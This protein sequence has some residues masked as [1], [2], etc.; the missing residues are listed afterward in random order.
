MKIIRENTVEVIDTKL[1]SVIIELDENEIV[2]L[3]DLY[4]SVSFNTIDHI[5]ITNKL[6]KGE[7]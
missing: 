1:D 3:Y 4:A 6:N 2:S 7:S 5:E